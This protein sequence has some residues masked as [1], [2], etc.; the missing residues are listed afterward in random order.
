MNFSANGQRATIPGQAGVS[1]E[2]PRYVLALAP[3]SK[4]TKN[5]NRR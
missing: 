2:L 1:A 3:L 4:Q 5:R